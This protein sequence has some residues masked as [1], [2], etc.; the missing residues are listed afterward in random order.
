MRRAVPFVVA[1]AVVAIA[2]S[3]AERTE[4][5]DL[6]LLVDLSGS[7]L[8]GLRAARMRIT[9]TDDR[10]SHPDIVLT[11]VDDAT[12][13]AIDIPLVCAADR[14]EARLSIGAGDYDVVAT[15]SAVDRCG[16]R[17]D[18]LA[19]AGRVSV[20]HWASSTVRL[21]P[22]DA[23]FDADD[24]GV[25][26]LL[27]AVSCG[28]FDLD[29]GP[30]LPHACSADDDTC[31]IDEAGSSGGQMVFAGRADH[32]LPY[33]LDGA[34]GNDT[35]A[36]APFAIDSTEMTWGAVRRCVDAGACFAEDAEH[37]VRRA[38]VDGVDAA[39]PARGLS[40][41][42]ADGVCAFF[43][44]RLARDRE[45]DF[46]AA[47]RGAAPR[48]RYPFEVDVDADA[49]G[50]LATDAPPAAAHRASGR[51]CGDG[52]PVRVGS[53]VASAI[54]RG[55]GTPVSELAGNVAEWTIVG[56]DVDEA[57]HVVL[58]GGGAGSFV[59]LL[60]NDLPLVFRV[61]DDDARIAAVS[62]VAGFRCTSD[63]SVAVEEPTC[64]VR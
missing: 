54:T 16:T 14:C 1:A 49:I 55:T 59:E 33:D 9:I 24:D 15:L 6:Q 11:D 3:C 4:A 60:E 8:D 47:D 38:L 48:A 45:W 43:G 28:R 34:A 22:S 12:A 26:D 31:C 51:A 23:G 61:G 40:P 35:V 18:L 10:G 41:V 39:T 63:V 52:E 44:K 5:E 27:E 21:Q 25:V 57:T 20:G 32:V 42:E 19:Y 2:S 30:G 7:S 64:P 37:P 36:V 50:C 56:D 62:S 58:R 53:F 29:D 13:E 17:A 46:V